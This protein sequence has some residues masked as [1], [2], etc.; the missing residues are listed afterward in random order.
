MDIY[1]IMM[2][3]LDPAFEPMN[4]KALEKEFENKGYE[5]IGI[6]YIELE[7]YFLVRK[8]K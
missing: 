7:P 3:E 6:K 2:M 1:I 8:I 5:L 4:Y